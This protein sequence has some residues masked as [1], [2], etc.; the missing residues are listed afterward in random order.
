M[1]AQPLCADPTCPA[2]FAEHDAHDG[3]PSRTPTDELCTDPAC[4]LS[5]AEHEAHGTYAGGDR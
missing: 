5:W 1:T 2:V 4:D 3:R